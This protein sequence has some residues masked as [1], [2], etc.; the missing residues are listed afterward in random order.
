MNFSLSHILPSRLLS[1]RQL[2][3][4]PNLF[5]T[6]IMEKEVFPFKVGATDAFMGYVEQGED[7][8]CVAPPAKLIEPST[9]DNLLGDHG[10]E[11]FSLP[12]SNSTTRTASPASTQ[13]AKRDDTNDSPS[14]DTTIEPEEGTEDGQ[15]NESSTS[16]SMKNTS[17][18]SPVL[19]CTECGK[20]LPKAR[21]F[22]YLQCHQCDPDNQHRR[23]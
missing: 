21:K 4:L 16:Q 6:V 1:S 3:P 22:W 18:S 20:R 7:E 13:L 19:L 14:G 15:T 2:K 12:N 23:R 11:L 17:S 5:Q 9:A 10:S 8:H